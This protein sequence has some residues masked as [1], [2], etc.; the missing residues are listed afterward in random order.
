MDYYVAVLAWKHLHPIGVKA[1]FVCFWLPKPHEGFI[2][3]QRFNFAKDNDII[4][5]YVIDEVLLFFY[6]YL[7]IQKTMAFLLWTFMFINNN[8]FYIWILMYL[9]NFVISFPSN[10]KT[11]EKLAILN[12]SLCQR[13]D[14]KT[15]NYY[16]NLIHKHL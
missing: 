1:Q 15:K 9:K 4:G 14:T 13:C 7:C 6:M 16:Y 2:C 3:I 8:K 11:F 5:I 12:T 10:N